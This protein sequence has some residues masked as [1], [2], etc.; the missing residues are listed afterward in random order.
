MAKKTLFIVGKGGGG[1]G[2][3]A[4]QALQDIRVVINDNF[5]S[6]TITEETPKSE[7]APIISDNLTEVE[8]RITIINEGND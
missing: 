1:G 8:E 2:G 3:E 7:Y 5:G 6:E 4:E